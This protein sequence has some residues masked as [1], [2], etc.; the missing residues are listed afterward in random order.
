M[1]EPCR[2]SVEL[3]C[4]PSKALIDE[5]ITPF[6]SKALIR[7]IPFSPPSWRT[8]SAGCTSVTQ[9]QGERGFSSLALLVP[10]TGLEPVRYRYRGILSPLRLPIPP[11]RLICPSLVVAASRL[12]SQ[13]PNPALFAA[14]EFVRKRAVVSPCANVFIIPNHTENVKHVLK[15]RPHARAS[16]GAVSARSFR[17]FDF[18]AQKT[19]QDFFVSCFPRSLTHKKG[20]DGFPSAPCLFAI[21]LLT[22]CTKRH[23][24][25]PSMQ[26]RHCSCR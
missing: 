14:P 6:A 19:L 26:P 24:W 2:I 9:R 15:C 10:L 7:K 20:A 18:P 22:R 17:P 25:L 13:T 23:G 21:L 3:F 11:Q 1:V 12:P 5:N 8:H 16:F 4:P